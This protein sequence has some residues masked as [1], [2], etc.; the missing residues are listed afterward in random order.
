M[1]VCMMHDGA[2]LAA[3]ARVRVLEVERERLLQDLAHRDAAL[4]GER[5]HEEE[6][7]VKGHWGTRLRVKGLS[8]CMCA[9]AGH[10]GMQRCGV[11][12]RRW[13]GC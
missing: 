3:R 2:G 4:H 13:S 5:H 6:D 10:D 11:G 7:G 8:P 9:C 1:H 12:R